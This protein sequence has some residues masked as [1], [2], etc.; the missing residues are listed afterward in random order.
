MADPTTRFLILFAG[1]TGST[2]IVETLNRHPGVCARYEALN[3]LENR[4]AAGRAAWARGFYEDADPALRA[5]GFKAKPYQM[6]EPERFAALARELGLKLVHLRRENVVKAAVSVLNGRR[7]RAATGRWHKLASDKALPVFAPAAHELWKWIA[8]RE[9][10]DRQIADFC[11]AAACPVLHLSYESFASERDAF[12]ARLAGYLGVDPA[13]MIPG[14]T[15]STK[16]T[17]P[18]LR[19]M[20]ANFDELAASLEGSIYREMLLD[21]EDKPGRWSGYR[22]ANTDVPTFAPA[23]VPA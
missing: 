1:R 7:L 21:D 8:E 12:T 4:S 17:P 14:P 19:A 13:P 15:E 10:L 20:L 18:D 2:A 5:I 6:I 3:E 11:L 23:P 9:R 22:P 16:V